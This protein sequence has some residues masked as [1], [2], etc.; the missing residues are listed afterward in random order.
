MQS[1]CWLDAF[2]TLC[3]PA[4]R[5][6]LEKACHVV[7][8]PQCAPVFGM[9]AAPTHFLMV[10]EGE[11]VV[12]QYS[13]RGRAIVLYRVRRGQTCILTTSCLISDEAYP[14][15][16]LAQSPIQ[17]ALLP[18][19]AFDRLLSESGDFRRF[20]FSSLGARLADLMSVIDQ[21][22]FARMEVRLCQTLLHL[23]KGAD[24]VTA[25]QQELAEELGGARGAVNR[26]LA[27]LAGRGL[28]ELHRGRIRLLDPAGLQRIAEDA[29]F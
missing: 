17:A 12:R 29:E 16:A 15:E 22:A 2:P 9:G 23:A 3:D 27:D 19:G 11:A 28:I 14:A 24:L 6:A 18:R 1:Q 5:L 7:S 10:V 13:E 20:V 25:T 26:R 8:L 4:L 21:I